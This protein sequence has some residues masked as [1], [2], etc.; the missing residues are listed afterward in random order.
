MHDDDTDG[1]GQATI[2]PPLYQGK[3]NDGQPLPPGA[4][5]VYVGDRGEW[6]VD[7]NAERRQAEM[8][9]A[10]VRRRSALPWPGDLPCEVSGYGPWV[11]TLFD[12]EVHVYSSQIYLESDVGPGEEGVPMDFVADFK[13]QRNG[14]CG[15]ATPGRLCMVTGTHTGDVPLAIQLHSAPP[16]VDER[17]EDIVEV[18][19][20]VE[21]W[22]V[23]L[24]PLLGEGVPLPLPLGHYRARY[25]AS[26]MDIELEPRLSACDERYLLQ[27]WRSDGPEPDR[28]VQG[29]SAR[30]GGWHS[31][32]SQRG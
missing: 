13:G 2:T 7:L 27:L 5:L 21:R 4:G 26:G 17:W 12:R 6:L 22:R 9:D 1:P 14:L 23:T 8:H 31:Q 32:L 29:G 18:S 15:A 11:V 19:F 30:A 20:H 3:A 24:I 28:I 10:E 16:P 25:C